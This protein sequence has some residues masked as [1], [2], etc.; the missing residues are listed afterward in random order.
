MLYSF[1]SEKNKKRSSEPNFDI[2]RKRLGE[3]IE[4]TPSHCLGEQILKIKVN[5]TVKKF[6]AITYDEERI[7]PGSVVIIVGVIGSVLIV[8]NYKNIL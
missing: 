8:T 6:N 3:V 7:L 5:N 1:K 4:Y 2:Y